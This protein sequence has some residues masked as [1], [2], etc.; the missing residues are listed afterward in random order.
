MN[1]EDNNKNT[2][3][4]TNILVEKENNNQE[5]DSNKKIQCG[6]ETNI[7]YNDVLEWLKN[8]YGYNNVKYINHTK[9]ELLTVYINAQ[10]VLY[11]EAKTYCEQKL[12]CLMIP[13]I[14][15][16]AVTGLISFI[17]IDKYT[18]S[19]IIAAI[20]AVNS[21][22]LAL[23]T[24]LKLDAK[25][26]AHKSTAYKL[27]KL[28]SQCEFKCGKTIEDTYDLS[29][30]IEYVEK[31]VK[32][33]KE[34]NQ[35]I[36]PEYIRY[37]F[38]YLTTTNIF[39]I[40]KVLQY[41]ESLVIHDLNMHMNMVSSSR[42]IYNKHKSDKESN[43]ENLKNILKIQDINKND[44]NFI[45]LVNDCKNLISVFQKKM[46]DEYY[47]LHENI[48]NQDKKINEVITFGKKYLDI[49]EQIKHEIN[50][51]HIKS[52]KYKYNI[53]NWLKT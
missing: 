50:S 37:S 6:L 22:L 30:F 20:S 36:L 16:S 4:V 32:E 38:P 19:L 29:E 17:S 25:A 35:F 47:F 44:D 11:T 28:Q 3:D 26:E 40:V 49:D 21:L 33:I 2:Y 8:I 14:I 52:Q 53:M 42:K 10:K 9:L 1:I 5:L 31:D 39:T 51:Y 7:N 48:K 23:V 43:E 15:I 13:T 12:Y 24:Y 27:E 45:N 18:S 34:T 41:E 46:D